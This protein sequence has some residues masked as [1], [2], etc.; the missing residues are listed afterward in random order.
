MTDV[1][2]L[3]PSVYLPSHS[4]KTDRLTLPVA[5]PTLLL[6]QDRCT[7][8]RQTYY[9]SP[10]TI[11]PLPLQRAEL[12][13]PL[14]PCPFPLIRSRADRTPTG[15]FLILPPSLPLP[16]SSFKTDRPAYD[17]PPPSFLAP[18]LLFAQDRPNN[19]PTYYPPSFP[20]PSPATRSKPSDV[21]T[22]SPPTPRP[23]PSPPHRSR[24]TNR[25]ADVSFP[26][27]F[28]ISPTRSRLTDSPIDAPPSTSLS[29]P[30]PLTRS[31]PTD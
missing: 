9:S 14:P 30:S 20:Y 17:A 16:S 8:Q 4:F 22:Q 15:E 23:C 18:S 27:P 12:P 3:L 28:R 29:Q 19:M 31:A 1:S 25:R 24:P 7:N 10:S 21:P 13:S 11:P 6:V 26:T 2:S 5:F